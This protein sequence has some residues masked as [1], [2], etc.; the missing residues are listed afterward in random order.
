MLLAT[1]QRVLKPYAV[2]RRSFNFCRNGLLH[3][4][5]KTSFKYMTSTYQHPMYK[6]I[7]ALRVM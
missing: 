7:P 5:V 1:F 6:K 2:N 4:A 3:Q